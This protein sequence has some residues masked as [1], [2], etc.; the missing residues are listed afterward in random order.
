[1]AN[2]KFISK[3]VAKIKGDEP[4]AKAARIQT[5]AKAA[6]NTQIALLESKK[7]EAENV[8]DDARAGLDDAIYPESL[9][10]SNSYIMGIKIAQKGVDAAEEALETIVDSIT[11]YKSVK[12]ETFG[13]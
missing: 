12:G 4:A 5:K 3:V 8:L 2:D 1:M 11:Y 10:D 7:A 13:E 6:F 9:A